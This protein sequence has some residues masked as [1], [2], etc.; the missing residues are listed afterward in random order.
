MISG[1]VYIYIY[2]NILER[3]E[4]LVSLFVEEATE[5]A[6]EEPGETPELVAQ[7]PKAKETPE[8]VAQTWQRTIKVRE[9]V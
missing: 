4:R 1:P 5:V 2:K 8:L 9:Q 7:T 6:G 3:L